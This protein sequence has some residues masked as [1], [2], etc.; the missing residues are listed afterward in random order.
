[1]PARAL[2]VGGTASHVGKSWVSTAI[3][4]L[5]FRRGVRVAPFKAQNMSNNSYPCPEGG[6]I[7]RAQ[8]AQ[9]EA[10]GLNPH[11]DM[12]PILLKPT[13][14]RGSQVVVQGRAWRNL[15]AQEYYEHHDYLEE[16]V[17]ESYQRLAAQYDFVVVEGAGSIAELNLARTDLVNMG[18]AKRF[19]I[20][21]LLVA[22]I[23]RGGVFGALH[24]TIDLLAKE[25][26]E[27]VRAFAVN[28]F[29]GDPALFVNGRRLL[30]EKT[31]KPCLGVFPYDAEIELDEEDG[32]ALDAR[33]AVKTGER[34]VAI[35][36]FPRVSNFGDFQLL[37]SARWLDGPV[38]ED[39]DAV[40]LPGTKNTVADLD[41]MR[42]RG[43]DEW[44]R[45]QY[46]RGA[47]VLG[48]C[49]G[50]QM[51]GE[52]IDDP[53]GM[54][55]DRPMTNGLGLLP[56][57]TVM[58]QEKTTTAVQAK[59]NKGVSFS[60][61]EI[62]MGR[63]RCPSGSEQLAWVGGRPE[64]M[65]MGRVAGCYLH[66]ALENADVVEEWLGFRPETAVAKE[67]SFDR[68]ADWLE[69]SADHDLLGDLLAM[70]E[71]STGLG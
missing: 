57:T 20:P 4:R 19:D 13:S 39:F 10:C 30:E 42:S 7:G 18:F 44:V 15:S 61:Y 37:R 5:L 70:G 17:S 1:M 12:N 41:W 31:G 21:V 50:F 14:E 66:G 33:Q 56:V 64:G 27:L 47:K 23:D 3:C 38:M 2:M 9:A 54:E 16:K 59:T 29:R 22:D 32:V 40:I 11:P 8:V 6:E 63:T 43:L 51:L 48:I 25:E 62:H 68:L 69:A 55:S 49:G 28:R 35:V 24:G 46:R 45:T 34:K 67:E 71:K 26:R 58:E 53:Y 36:R 52:R 65:R 60:A